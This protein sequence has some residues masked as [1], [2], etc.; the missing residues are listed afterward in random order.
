MPD[1]GAGRRVA[2]SPQHER[3]FSVPRYYDVAFGYRDFVAECD[4]LCETAARRL[5]RAPTSAVELAAGPAN[6]AVEL[7]RR[8]IA[9]HALDREPE[10]VRYG[11]D[12]A[13]AAGVALD[14]R[15]GDI[16]GLAPWSGIDVALLLLGS[17]GS[18]LTLDDGLACLTATAASLAPDGLLFLELPHPRSLFGDDEGTEAGWEVTG[19]GLRVRV[20][21]GAEDDRFDP[22]GQVGEVTTTLTVW[23]QGRKKVIRDRALQRRWTAQDLIALARL[24]GRFEIVAWYGALDAAIPIDDAEQAWR[25]VLAMQRTAPP[26]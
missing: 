11:C 10:M 21:W 5:G 6:H 7:A 15:L 26:R 20:R 25:M 3:I 9:A 14:Y 19:D 12:K 17:A 4:F 16:T 23:D 22:V 2:T 1:R 8:G 13:A 18:L 24:S